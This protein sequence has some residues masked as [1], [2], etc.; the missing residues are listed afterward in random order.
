MTSKR[1]TNGTH[2]TVSPEETRARIWPLLRPLGIT[3]VANI[4]GLDHVG[5]PV[6]AV[7]R[8]NSRSLSVAQGK[9]CTLTCAEVSGV[10][11]SI[12]FHHAE[13]I[14]RPLLYGSFNQLRY[15]HSLVVPETLPQSGVGRYTP[16]FKLP[17]IEGVDLIQETASWVPFELVHVD[18]TLPLPPGSGCFP[19]TSNGLASGNHLWEAVSHGLCEVVE[20]DGATLFSLL[21][22]AEREARRVDPST[23]DSPECQRLLQRFS[24]AGLALAIYD[25]TS[26]VGIAIFRVVVTDQELN[27]S[28]PL[29]PSTGTGCHCTRGV[30][31]SRALTEAAQSRLTVISGS[32]DDLPRERYASAADLVQLRARRERV[33]RGDTPQAFAEAPNFESDD[34]GE[35]V[36]WQKERLANI[37]VERLITVDLT[38]PELDIPVVRVIIPGLE[39]ARDVPGWVPGPRARQYLKEHAA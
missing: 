1:H 28:R 30:A 18:L 26:D 14:S 19:T 23:V 27:E 10:M 15:T 9:G 24:D 31:L 12:E 21:S 17:W 4:T 38:K 11:E 36:V 22:D 34:I 32:R 37:G 25:M 29:A 7:Y 35:D 39:P 2:R 33:L 3:R 8:P 20:R 6:V 5:I 16:D 13:N